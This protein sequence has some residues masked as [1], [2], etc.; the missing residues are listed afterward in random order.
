[1][2]CAW[3]ALH[4]NYKDNYQYTYIVKQIRLTQADGEV[5]SASTATVANGIAFREIWQHC[6]PVKI[7][8]DLQDLTFNTSVVH[9]IHSTWQA[10]G[11]KNRDSSLKFKTTQPFWIKQT[12][13]ERCFSI[14][15]SG[16]QSP[17]IINIHFSADAAGVRGTYF[18]CLFAQ[19]RRSS[20][21]VLPSVRL[22]LA[23][24]FP[25]ADRPL[26]SCLSSKRSTVTAHSIKWFQLMDQLSGLCL[27]SYISEIL[28]S[29]SELLIGHMGRQ[30][31]PRS[32]RVP[33]SRLGKYLVLS[34]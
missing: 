30:C 26:Q 14:K 34:K 18:V 8:P 15:T 29:I 28:F 20:V 10:Q 3:R 1:M 21:W 24:V 17:S 7:H 22:Q 13:F 5:R 4:N 31:L 25:G 2:Q 9:L 23:V 19:G 32:W 6:N 33:L 16:I 12:V 27:D 11:D